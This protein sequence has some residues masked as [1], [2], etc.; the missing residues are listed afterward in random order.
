MLD[1]VHRLVSG[2]DQGSGAAEGTLCRVDYADGG[3]N[4]EGLSVRPRSARQGHFR[5]SYA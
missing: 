5:E 1:A 4:V 2:V 3:C